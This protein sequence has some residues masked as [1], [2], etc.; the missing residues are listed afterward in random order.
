M[1]LTEN[2]IKT[3]KKD[4]IQNWI[5][6][7][8]ECIAIIGGIAGFIKLFSNDVDIQ[9]QIIELKIIS[10]Q[11]IEQTKEFKKQ[12]E[13][14]QLKYNLD[15][16]TQKKQEKNW[17]TSILPSL[18]LSVTSFDIRT[19]SFSTKLITT[20]GT[21]KIIKV[22]PFKDN[23]FKLNIPYTTIANNSPI[24][25]EL[26]KGETNEAKLHFLIVFEDM[27]GNK[28]NQIFNTLNTNDELIITTTKPEKT[29]K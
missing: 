12:S 17:E 26:E 27:E 4:N 10:R 14:L 21:A 7:I 1:R 5:R 8:A 20:G 3:C 25:L 13:L 24:D 16:V 22:T 2:K 23:T 19:I 9:N 11:A 18:T 6:T 29:K 15:S 28:Y